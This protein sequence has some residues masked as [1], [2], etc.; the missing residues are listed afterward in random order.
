[1]PCFRKRGTIASSTGTALR[2]TLRTTKKG[3]TTKCRPGHHRFYKW[4][5]VVEWYGWKSRT[6]LLCLHTQMRAPR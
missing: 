1:M 5:P 4:Q 6:C 3:T 2:W